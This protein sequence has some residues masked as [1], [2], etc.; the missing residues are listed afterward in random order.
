MLLGGGG[1]VQ[2]LPGGG[3][4]KGC[5]VEGG[6]RVAWWMGYK[7]CLVEGEVQGLPGGGGY[8][9]CLVEGEV[10]GLSGAHTESPQSEQE[11]SS[12]VWTVSP[13]LLR[14]CRWPDDSR[15]SLQGVGVVGRN[16]HP[17]T[18]IET[19]WWWWWWYWWGWWGRSAYKDC[20]LEEW[21]GG[22]VQGLPSGGGGE[23]YKSC[24]VEGGERYKGCLVEGGRGTRVA[25]WRGER[26]KGCLVEGGERY[27]GCL[28][29]GGGEVQGLPGGGG[30]VQ[31]LPRG[32]G[33]RGTR[34]AWWRGRGTRVA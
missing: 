8:K 29:E 11:A 20:L 3:G 4:Y 2:G 6:T 15:V 33:G 27:K 9:G 17:A 12:S 28:V 30:E 21:E 7:G 34:V 25:W 31:G 16:Y 18:L 1:E 23:R 14:L 24:L 32:G 19:S 26:Y 10:Q 5:L 22:E 13:V